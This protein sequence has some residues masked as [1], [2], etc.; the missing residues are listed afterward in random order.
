MWLDDQNTKCETPG[1]SVDTALY[2]Q[3][4]LHECIIKPKPYRM[5]ECEDKQIARKNHPEVFRPLENR[6]DRRRHVLMLTYARGGS[7][8]LGQLFNQHEDAFY[9]FEP[10]H[11]YH[12]RH[13]PN[14][15]PDGYLFTDDDKSS[16]LTN[17]GIFA[18]LEIMHSIFNCNLHSV[19]LHVFANRF[20]RTWP[21]PLKFASYR[22]CMDAKPKSEV[23]RA[24]SAFV[25]Q[26][27][28]KRIYSLTPRDL[29]G[30]ISLIK[31][32]IEFV[33]DESISY[34]EE[35]ELGYL[36]PF[37]IK[38]CL[39]LLENACRKAKVIAIK[40]IRYAMEF[41][42]LLGNHTDK[43]IH[44][45]RDPRGIMNSRYNGMLKPTEAENARFVC[46]HMSADL[47]ERKS[48]NR[49]DFFFPLKYEDLAAKPLSVAK[50]IYR[51]IGMD[52]SAKTL[53]RIWEMTHGGKDGGKS[54]TKR[55]NSTATALAWRSKMDNETVNV[56]NRRCAKT[57][58]QYGYDL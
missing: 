50:R 12:K 20:L 19:P 54:D 42:P 52:S 17:E 22:E 6:T 2:I 46:N 27:N 33:D 7:T 51:F 48:Q 34:L 32:K 15:S 40:T 37:K 30:N 35:S 43:V 5:C 39:P 45:S 56:I 21:V 4:E 29:N 49:L 38:Y 23:I 55:K 8:L 3:N 58:S 26:G 47:R 10:L 16:S 1:T 24:S 11:S 25:G 41:V 36:L 18:H 13:F 14:T 9:W 57:L 53:N 28:F 44:L 31:E